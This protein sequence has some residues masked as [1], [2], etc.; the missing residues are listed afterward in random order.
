MTTLIQDLRCG[1]RMLLKQ[2]GFTMIA[3]ITLALGVGANTAIFSVP[4]RL[5]LKSLPVHKA[6][7]LVLFPSLYTSA[8]VTATRPE[9][10]SLCEGES[11]LEL[12]RQQA[13]V[14][15]TLDNTVQRIAVLIRAADL[16]WPY[17]EKAARAA[18]TEAFD[19]ATTHEKEKSDTAKRPIILL[20]F[21]PDER[22]V[23]I[24]AV[25]R[26]DSVWA[27][28]LTKET[29]DQEK[30][31]AD[32]S[33]TRDL[34]DDVMIA[35]RLLDSGIKLLSTD[36]TQ[37]QEIAAMSL[38]YP[39][40]AEL[41]RFLY[42]LAATNQQAADQFYLNALTTYSSKP[43]REFLY[44]QAYPFGFREGGDMPVFGYYQVPP[45]FVPNRLL[46][47][48]FVQTLLQRAQQA[49][50][51]PLDDGDNYNRIPGTAHILQVLTRVEPKVAE[52]LPDLLPAVVQTKERILVSLP[53]ETQKVLARSERST[54]TPPPMSFAERMEAAA[55]TP[56]VHKRDELIVTAIISTIQLHHDSGS[57][58]AS[59]E[60]LVQGLDQIGDPEVRSWLA[61]W[62]Y[63]SKTNDAIKKKQL[64]E[65]LATVAKVEDLEL[66]TYLRGEIAKAFVDQPETAMQAREILDQAIT[67]ANKGNKT[68]LAARILFTA[69]IVYSRLNLSRSFTV[70]ADAIKCT[71]GIESPN[72]RDDQQDSFINAK[73]LQRSVVFWLPGF[74]P[75]GA[76]REMAKR[77][78]DGSFTQVNTLT[79][80][81]QRAMSSMAVSEVCLQQIRQP[82]KPQRRTRVMRF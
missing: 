37:A 26:R 1:L 16:M 31:W 80:K 36:T 61:E 6:E 75:E 38:R 28:K 35:Q 27:R 81:F 17:R 65:A 21:V 64:S 66:R 45:N 69:A 73:S 60:A 30:R 10:P 22:Y 56:D 55:K 43:M 42:Q 12:I 4:D 8:Q 67:E 33:L 49:L 74:D 15:K 78:F 20:M 57:E 11:A 24:R 40:S 53:L 68:I 19:V 52:L 34:R 29:L 18:F 5:L 25:F 59:L 47:R 41:S 54:G 2:P 72:F 14:A 58:M 9:T 76:F 48:R 3:V 71:N 70:L 62:V 32:E 79:D 51:V 7:Q 46:Q 13:E 44:L 82:R 39:A 50:E 23:V 63:F 77:D